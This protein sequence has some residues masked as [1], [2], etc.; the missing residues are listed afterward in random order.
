MSKAEK[1]LKAYIDKFH[2]NIDENNLRV[3][4]LINYSIR[5]ELTESQALPKSYKNVSKFYE[6]NKETE[7]VKIKLQEIRDRFNSI[8][9][10]DGNA[11]NTCF[12]DFLLW[13]CEQPQTVD[14]HHCCHYC[15]IPENLIVSA[16]DNPRFKKSS[17][18][19]FS[20][21][22]QVDQKKPKEGYNSD[23]CVLACVLCNNAKSDMIDAKDFADF[24]AP[25]IREYWKALLNKETD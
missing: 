17:K 16:M 21:K 20:E 13:W 25:A 12:A 24:I 22:L 19:S 23:N 11:F 6:D 2:N 7:T 3:D 15:G 4:F 9:S 10:R 1:A 8:L 18:T 14:G 5:R